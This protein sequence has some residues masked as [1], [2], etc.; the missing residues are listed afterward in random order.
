VTP[1]TAWLARHSLL[2]ASLA[3]SVAI[4]GAAGV[5]S[6]TQEV[7]GREEALVIDHRTLADFDRLP[8]SDIGAAAGLRF[9]LRSASIGW[10]MDQGLS[11]LMN[12]FADRRRRPNFCDRGIPPGQV[13]YDARYDRRNWRI[14]LRG[15]PG[16]YGKVTDFV[17]RLNGLKPG[18]SFD[19]VGFNFNY[20]DGVEGSA[21]VDQFFSTSNTRPVTAAAL[22]T[23][24]KRHPGTIFVWWSM[25]LP[26]RS[27][28]TMQQFNVRM[29]AYALER[30]KVFFDLA[31]IGSHRPDGSPCTDNQGQGLEA[32][33]Q[34]YTDERNSGHLNARGSQRAA[35]A[36]W[37]LMARLA[38][39][40]R[41]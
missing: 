23:L 30:K 34:E 31:D 39:S 20:S 32:L 24:E 9:L 1:A 6:N 29:R 13:V 41:I 35:K 5:R 36:I 28:P 4:L 14:E 2:A 26:R 7:A 38:A 10:N 15:N 33:C 21:I 8:D 19:V 11:C 25:A 17:D 22:E 27:S 12:S 37:V 3:L 40:G 16:W 18:E